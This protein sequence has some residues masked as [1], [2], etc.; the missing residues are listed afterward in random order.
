MGFILAL[1]FPLLLGDCPAILKDG[2]VVLLSAKHR[3]LNRDGKCTNIHE[4]STHLLLVTIP[5]FQVMKT[6]QELNLKA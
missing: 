4:I 2:T 1:L 5:S 6:S 3:L